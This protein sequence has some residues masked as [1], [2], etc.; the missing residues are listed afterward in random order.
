MSGG[1]YNYSSFHIQEIAEQIE[2][3][4]N[5]NE[6][7]CMTYEVLTR[8][9]TLRDRLNDIAVAVHNADYLYSGDISEETFIERF[10]NNHK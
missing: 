1:H 5:E 8:M 9:R 7:H 2:Q 6:K 4:I 3:D 10:D